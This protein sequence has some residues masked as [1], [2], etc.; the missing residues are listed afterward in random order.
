MNLPRYHSPVLLDEVPSTNSYAKEHYSGLSD[1]QTVCARC[2]T[3]GRGRTG[4][5]WLSPAGKC[6][7]GTAVFKNLHDGFHGG[8]VLGI[9]VL[10]ALA[11]AVPGLPCYLKW[12][13]DLYVN[14]RKLGGILCE[15]VEYTGGRITGAAAGAGINLNMNEA[16]LAAAGQPAESLSRFCGREFNPDLMA[17]NIAEQIFKC[18]I[19]YLN[20]PM[21]ILSE[22][23]RYNLLR[24]E[25][26]SIETPAGEMLDGIFEDID[27]CGRMLFRGG[28]GLV[29]FGCGDVHI[30]RGKIDFEQ[31]NAKLAGIKQSETG[32]V[33][34]QT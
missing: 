25:K 9:A 17:R 28:E 1:G 33:N 32:A 12:P 10:R 15:G 27:S 4:R 11:E 31:I 16:E 29:T 13:N 2:Q 3:A 7:A 23:R 18:Y 20:A 30:D 5:R 21:E 34:G 19:S 6:F 8:A 26:I 24:G 22:W 14:G